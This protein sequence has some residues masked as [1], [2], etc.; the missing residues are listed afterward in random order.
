MDRLESMSTLLAAAETGS[1]SA[2]S[3]KPN[4]PL[5]TVS[6]KVSE[7][8]GAPQ[9]PAGQPHEPGSLRGRCVSV[10]SGAGDEHDQISGLP[11]ILRATRRPNFISG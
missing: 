8:R 1:L 11:S 3:R 9:D 2:V 7:F 5:A 4:I 6:R 10:Y